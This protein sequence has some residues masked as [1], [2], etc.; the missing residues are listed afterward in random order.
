MADPTR[1]AI[2]QADPTTA[3]LLQR[4]AVDDTEAEP[5]DVVF[6]LVKEAGRRAMQSLDERARVDPESVDLAEINWLYQRIDE[7]ND[8][9]SI[10]D[11]AEQLL[12]WLAGRPEEIHR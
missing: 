5:H 12:A 7:M 10:V 2:E 11:A 1:D 9:E 3:D 6:R 4:L 8:E